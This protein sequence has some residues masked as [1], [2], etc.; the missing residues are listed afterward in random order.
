MNVTDE[1]A[2]TSAITAA[3]LKVKPLEWQLHAGSPY[4]RKAYWA[5]APFNT[6]YVVREERETGDIIAFH[7]T[8]VYECESLADGDPYPTEEAAIAACNADCERRLLAALDVGNPH[9]QD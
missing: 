5:D 3:T 8:S 4:H 2:R 7:F 6:G 1:I 9:G